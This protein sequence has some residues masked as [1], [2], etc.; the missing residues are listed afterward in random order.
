M[1]GAIVMQS[2][3]PIT[4]KADRQKRTILSSCN[5]EICATNMGS[6]LTV[7]TRNMI[8]SLANLGYPILDCTSPT[9]VYNNNNACVK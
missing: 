6:C 7:K 4:W 3:D 8:S 2:G 1:S 9:H 5:A